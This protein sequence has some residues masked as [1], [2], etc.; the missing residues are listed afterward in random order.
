LA[1]PAAG[2]QRRADVLRRPLRRG[3]AIGFLVPRAAR[4]RHRHRACLGGGR[5]R[6]SSPAGLTRLLCLLLLALLLLALL[7]LLLRQAPLQ[8]HWRRVGH[9]DGELACMAVEAGEMERWVRWECCQC[10]CDV[11][12]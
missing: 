9:C 11:M 4:H 6:G 3:H 5:Q 1:A 2:L 7:L 8:L 12:V 10:R